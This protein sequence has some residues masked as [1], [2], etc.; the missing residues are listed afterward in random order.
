MFDCLHAGQ[1]VHTPQP[2]PAHEI[3]LIPYHELH[4]VALLKNVVGR[5]KFD[6]VVNR[7]SWRDRRRVLPGMDGAAR[8]GLNRIQSPEFSREVAGADKKNIPEPFVRIG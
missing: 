8:S 1:H 6:D 4:P 2:W 5:H 7:L 3:I